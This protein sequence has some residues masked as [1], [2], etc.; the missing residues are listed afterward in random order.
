MALQSKEHRIL[1]HW[2]SWFESLSKLF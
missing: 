1:E 2:D